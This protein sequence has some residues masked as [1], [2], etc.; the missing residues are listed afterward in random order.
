M[1]EL[2]KDIAGYEREYQISNLG[3]VRSLDRVVTYNNGVDVK[4]NGKILSVFVKKNGYLQATLKRNSNNKK[5]YVHRLVALAFIDNDDPIH[6]IE[7][8][9]IDEDKKNN[10]VNNLEWVT[11]SEN[12]RHNDLHIRKAANTD[13]TII[14]NKLK[15][16]I[17]ATNVITGEE[18]YFNGAMDAERL[19]GFKHQHIAKV[20]KGK[21]KSHKGYKFRYAV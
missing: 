12:K 9:H 11:S 17:V 2:W 7:I 3:R 5:F 21:A 20:C 4:Y 8:N 1:E 10:N 13:F 19:M 18:M 16:P 14:A 6:K 15:I